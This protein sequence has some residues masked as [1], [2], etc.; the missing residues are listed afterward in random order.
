VTTTIAIAAPVNTKTVVAMLMAAK[1]VVAAKSV[2]ATLG[3]ATH[4]FA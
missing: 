3:A 1:S 4:D 2:M